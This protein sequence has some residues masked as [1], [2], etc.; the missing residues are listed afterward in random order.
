M[1]KVWLA[2][3]LRGRLRFLGPLGSTGL[4]AG[5]STGVAGTVAWVR[6]GVC[7]TLSI[8]TLERACWSSAAQGGWYGQLTRMTDTVVGMIPDD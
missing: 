4:I 2:D 3:T 7:S 8:L 5:D 1:S 6:C